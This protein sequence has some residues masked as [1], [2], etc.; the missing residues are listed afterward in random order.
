MYNLIAIYN[1]FKLKIKR[2]QLYFKDNQKIKTKELHASM[3]F[4]FWS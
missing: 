2:I 4:G 1:E 3:M